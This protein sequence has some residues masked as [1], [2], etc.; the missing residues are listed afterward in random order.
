MNLSDIQK[1]P[2]VDVDTETK[3]GIDLPSV[4]RERYLS[5]PQADLL[6][7][8]YKLP[9][10]DTKLWVPGDCIPIFFKQPNNFRF[11]AFN[12]LF[13]YSVFNKFQKRYGF[14][15]PKLEHM[16][17]IMAVAA[18]YGLPQSL[19]SLGRVLDVSLPKKKIGDSLMKACCF[20]PFKPTPEQWKEFCEYC[21]RDTDSLNEIRSKLPRPCLPV[22]EQEC[23][24]ETM[25]ANLDGV[26]VDS[27]SVKQVRKIVEYYID[28]QTRRISVVSKGKLYSP[29]Q[30]KAIVAYAAERGIRMDN[31]QAPT[32][33]AK[34]L[35]AED[36]GVTDVATI[37]KIRKL[38]GGA[39]VKKFRRL[40]D[41]ACNGR[42]FDNMRHHGAGTGRVTGGGFQMLNLSRAKVKAEEGETYDQAVER[43]LKTFF[44]V[45]VLNHPDPMEQAKKLI[46]PMLKARDRYR[47]LV[48]D[49]GSIE[50]ILL[51]Y[52]SGQWEKCG[53]FAAGKDPYVMFATD[54]FHT[55]YD[56]VTKAQRQMAKPPVLGSGYLL[57]AK[58]LI[59]YAEGYGVDMTAEQAT[60][61]TNTYR[62]T[63]P[64][65]VKTWHALRRCATMAVSGN[66]G[67]EHHAFILDGEH[68]LN[69]MFKCVTDHSNHKWLI[70]KL[71]SGRCL[72]YFSPHMR[73]GPYGKEIWHWGVDPK[74]KQWS[75]VPLKPQRIIENII[76]GLGRDILYGALSQLRAAGFKPVV[77]AYD[78]IV[79]EE[80]EDGSQH[81][82]QE[83]IDIMCRKPKWMP[84]LP[85][86]ASGYVSQRYMKD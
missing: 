44:D 20:P 12:A 68:S 41:M 35:E 24:I 71:P 85:L 21:I 75:R 43:V 55:E 33:A 19:E 82:L 4:G 65:V 13:D 5:H 86:K 25:V 39:A 10:E 73:I 78:E 61:A 14:K 46:R 36:R 50:Y 17:D 69:T 18:R 16:V 72:Y 37:L 54:L 53:Q 84:Y 57:S 1:L 27:W 76:Q 3:S 60:Y 83:M 40:D 2:I 77:H 80:P 8:S 30:A 7:F 6:M 81:R 45:S 59:A 63:N 15:A 28:K 64:N 62:E 23:W 32:V 74:T 51:M 42:I 22:E 34:L 26:P 66:E 31:L 49:W 67:V 70:L 9:G 29:Y 56:K 48:A 38:V 11:S 58:G 52:Y 79:C 47:L